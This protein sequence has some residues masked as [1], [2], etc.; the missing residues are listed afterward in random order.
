MVSHH[1]EVYKKFWVRRF[2]VE[3]IGSGLGFGIRVYR[4]TYRRRLALSRTLLED[5]HRSPCSKKWFRAL[6]LG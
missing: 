4:I 2:W 3:T 6:G 1:F 5:L